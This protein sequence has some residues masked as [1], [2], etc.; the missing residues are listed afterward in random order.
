MIWLDD[1]GHIV[2]RSAYNSQSLENIIEYQKALI[3]LLQT[4][5]KNL[6]N[7]DTTYSA[8]SL[9]EDMLFV[10]EQINIKDNLQLIADKAV[11]EIS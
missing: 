11:Q 2:I 3:H 9:L 7:Q 6:V 4:Q 5:D 10:P 1:E 8:L